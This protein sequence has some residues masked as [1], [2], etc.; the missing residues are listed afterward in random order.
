MAAPETATVKRVSP[1]NS[2]ISH[3]EISS[4]F[5]YIYYGPATGWQAFGPFLFPIFYPPYGG[6]TSD[7][8]P[9]FP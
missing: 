4:R 8:F 2:G 5:H 9:R 3:P 7:Y 6:S 1:G